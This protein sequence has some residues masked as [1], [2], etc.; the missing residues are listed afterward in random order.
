M[1]RKF[2]RLRMTRIERIFADLIRVHP[3]NPRS[4]SWSNEQEIQ[5][6]ADDAD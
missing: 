1:N 4:I 2:N 5:S 3:P 6:T